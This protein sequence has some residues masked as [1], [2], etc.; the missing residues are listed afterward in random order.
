M[1]AVIL[2]LCILLVSC[3]LVYADRGLISLMPDVSIFEPGQKAVVAWNGHEEILILSTDVS[4]S[5]ET[6]VLEIIPLPSM[7]V[8]QEASTQC[9]QEVQNMIWMYAGSPTFGYGGRG[10]MSSGVEI[11]FHQQIGAHNITVVSATDSA[12]L[13]DLANSFLMASGVNRNVTLESFQGAIDS[14]LGRGFMYFSLDLV[15]FSQQEESVEPILYR[16]NSSMLFYPLV[17]TSP[18]GGYGNITVFALTQDRID[19]RSF[20]ADHIPMLP[21]Y[22]TSATGQRQIIQFRLPNDELPRMD[23]RLNDLLPNGA[24]LTVLKADNVNLSLL[25]QD[26]IITERDFDNDNGPAYIVLPIGASDLSFVLSALIAG[27]LLAAA[28]SAF[29]FTMRK[30]RKKSGQG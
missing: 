12:S 4:A 15:T 21:A 14:Y 3:P 27:L 7:P 8:V 28:G 24:W 5:K 6:L 10:F 13:L 1:K 25:S 30:K 2:F 23:L 17:I 16:F 9:F 26:L 11:L 29:F 18:L 19:E 22:Y 20:G